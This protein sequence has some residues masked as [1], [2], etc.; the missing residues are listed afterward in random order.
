MADFTFDNLFRGF[1]TGLNIANSRFDHAARIQELKSQEALR[2]AQERQVAMHTA[3]LMEEQNRKIQFGADMQKAIGQTILESS[4]VIPAPGAVGGVLPN[5]NPMPQSRALLKNVGPVIG[6]YAPDKFAPFVQDVALSEFQP[7]GGEVTLPSGEKVQYFQGSRNSSV[8]VLSQ[9]REVTLP[10]GER[11]IQTGP[12]TYRPIPQDIGARQTK[13]KMLDFA[14]KNPDLS[15]PDP[16]NPDSRIIPPEN[17]AEAAKRMSLPV[18]V[19][20]ELEKQQSTG[21][22]L[23]SLGR[24]LLPMISNETAGPGGAISRAKEFIGGVTGIDTGTKATVAASVADRFRAMMTKLQK[25][26][27]NIAEPERKEIAKSMPNLRNLAQAPNQA[28]AL[29]VNNL[30]DWG[31]RSRRNAIKLGKPITPMW[32]T[33]EEVFQQLK[34]HKIS[35]QEADSIMQDNGWE[36]TK[37][38]GG[39]GRPKQ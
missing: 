6:K 21:D 2:Q 30:E 22:T 12:N 4:P 32:L 14:L 39:Y 17:W 16:D 31:N 18:G 7:K 29:T 1:N 13:Q 36:F 11:V 24:E 19:R 23:V 25:T 15:V 37:M 35:E 28:I 38:F 9:P 3:L 8:P 5:P 20:S 26:D 27:G 10:S 34:D 33:K